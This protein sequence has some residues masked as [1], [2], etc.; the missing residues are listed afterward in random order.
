MVKRTIKKKNRRVFLFRAIGLI[1]REVPSSSLADFLKTSVQ[2]F[3]PSQIGLMF[4]FKNMKYLR[5]LSAD[6]PSTETLFVQI[7]HYAETIRLAYS[8]SN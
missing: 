4:V 6:S 7:V 5:K 3:D 1:P 8:S 2:S